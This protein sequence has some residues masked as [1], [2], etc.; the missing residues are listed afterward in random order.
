[1]SP[2]PDP[3]EP[4]FAALADPTRRRVM[5]S[6]SERGPA[7]A[8]RLARDLPVTRQAVAKHLAALQE[9]GL[10]AGERVGREHRYRLTPAPLADAVSWMASVGARWDERLD[11]LRSL[12]HRGPR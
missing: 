6:L 8:T 1:M 5:L 3:V 12:V 11:R 9:A 10:V 4:V 2:S 7:T